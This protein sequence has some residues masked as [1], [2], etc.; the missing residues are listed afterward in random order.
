MERLRRWLGRLLAHAGF[1]GETS[2]RPIEAEATTAEGVRVV[3]FADTWSKHILARTGHPELAIQLD[4]VLATISFP[5]HREPDARAHRER[6]FK[7]NVGPSRWLMVVV[8]F[9]REPARIVTALGYGH[10][11]APRGWIT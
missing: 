1:A 5:D 6:F 7:E 3:L 2:R 4:A 9:E 8:D 10:G 11:R